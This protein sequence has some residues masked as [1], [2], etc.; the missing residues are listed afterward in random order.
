MKKRLYFGLD[1]PASEDVLIIHYPLIE[2]CGLPKNDPEIQKGLAFAKTCSH[3]IVTSK[4]A[5]RYL[6]DLE[7][8][9]APDSSF[10]SVGKATTREL[11]KQGYFNIHTASDESQEG[12][13]SLLSSMVFPNASFFWPH[14]S[15]S[16]NKLGEF[17]KRKRYPFFACVLYETHKS[18]PKNT[19]SFDDVDELFF[20]SPSTVD[21][22][23]K[24][25]KKLP[26]GKRV[27]T[28]GPITEKTLKKYTKECLW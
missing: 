20:S 22:F 26:E 4:M 7:P 5:V 18:L 3:I 27:L 13:I 1:F 9:F 28:Q 8:T 21:A 6:F 14:S 25:F 16:R 19:I 10:I 17:L 23:F 2:T 15:L 24:F 12:I 11:E